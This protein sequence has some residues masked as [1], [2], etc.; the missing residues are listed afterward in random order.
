MAD[1]HDFLLNAGVKIDASQAS[2]EIKDFVES[3]KSSF[4]N[5]KSTDSL[6]KKIQELGAEAVKNGNKIKEFYKII[7]NQAVKFNV[8]KSGRVELGKDKIVYKDI[9]A[10]LKHQ[11]E[12]EEEKDKQIQKQKDAYQKISDKIFIMTSELKMGVYQARDFSRIA[13][14]IQNLKLGFNSLTAEDAQKAQEE[15]NKLSGLLKEQ[16]EKFKGLALTIRQAMTV[17]GEGPIDELKTKLRD[18]KFEMK[19]MSSEILQKGM[20]GSTKDVE[21]DLEELNKKA[22]EVKQTRIELQTLD[23]KLEITW[24]EITGGAKGKAKAEL[25]VLK[26]KLAN[27]KEQFKTLGETSGPAFDE[28]KRNAFETQRQIE[29]LTKKVKPSQIKKL[30]TTIKRV[31]FYRIARNIFK[32]IENGFKEF[33]SQ[34]VG[35][36]DH[37]NTT[38]SQTNTAVDKINASFALMLS[39]L[40]GLISP[41]LNDIADSFANFANDISKTTAVIKGQ[42]KYLA[43]S[44]DYWHDMAEEANSLNASFDKFETLSDG[45]TS[46]GDIFEEIGI[47]EGEAEAVG[48]TELANNLRK[49]QEL[50]LTKTLRDVYSAVESL[51]RIA[52]TI[53]PSFKK[54]L[55]VFLLILPSLVDFAETVLDVVAKVVLW[56]DKNNLLIPALLTLGAVLAGIKFVGAIKHIK[57]MG[58][59][60][61]RLV[62]TMG[63]LVAAFSIFVI[64]KEAPQWTKYLMLVVGGLVAVAGAILAIKSATRGI[65]GIVASVGAAIT[66]GA[67]LSLVAKKT[68]NDV[69]KMKDG[70][71]LPKGTPFIAGEAGAELVHSM[72]NSNK[73]GVTNIEQFTQAMINANYQSSGLFQSLIE[74]ALNNCGYLFETN[75]DGAAVARSKSFKN[76]LNRTNS[77]LNLK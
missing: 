51:W 11:Q 4:Q 72:P 8:T 55:D 57:E 33:Q 9:T 17:A 52:K 62:G 1:K 21:A 5:T 44:K 49:I 20:K 64:L 65:A 28:I 29:K 71:V 16:E 41:I 30:A 68:A 7:G 10:E 14:N 6:K 25:D 34:L 45:G 13:R 39:S 24:A 26:A 3:V 42:N 58:L 18:L 59:S 61:N 36:G 38:V 75:I 63:L 40:S 56:L 76:E 31:G 67:T 47:T 53:Y 35:F 70:G 22:Q 12:I 74:A 48:A 66:L 2:N 73:T 27:F 50:D 46:K 23:S 54:I 15:T 69:P 19:A 43:I 37:I 32:T 60:I 77:G